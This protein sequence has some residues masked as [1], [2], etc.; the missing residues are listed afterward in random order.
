MALRLCVVLA[1]TFAGLLGG[2]TGAKAA[3]TIY[4]VGVFNNVGVSNPSRLLGNNPNTNN[5]QRNDSIGLLYGSDITTFTLSFVVT[6]FSGNTTFVAVRLG[7]WNGTTFT[8]ATG[9]GLLNPSGAATQNI[10]FEVT[11]P[12]AY[13]VNTR[14]YD[15]S[16]QAIGGCNALRFRN[17]S[18]SANGS[19]FQL[20]MV[21]AT[22]EP[23]V[24]ALM[25]FGF[26]GV[27]WRM[28]TLRRAGAL[29][30][31]LARASAAA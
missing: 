14:V 31:D 15:A 23:K 4:P 5:I 6:G 21:G 25:I 24:W 3:T 10:F 7:N 1:L 16:C 26:L 8:P 11:G 12:G 17:S 28:K 19:N 9:A 22:P 27:A 18:F 29:T 30:R 13:W 20:S 2:A